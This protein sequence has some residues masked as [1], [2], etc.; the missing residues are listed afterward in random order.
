MSEE[1]ITRNPLSF[2][3]IDS[4]QVKSSKIFIKL[5]IIT[6]SIYVV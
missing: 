4:E 6:V 1:F 5:I 2:C 3:L